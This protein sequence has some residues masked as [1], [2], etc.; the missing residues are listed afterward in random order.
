MGE[1]EQHR[2]IGWTVCLVF[3]VLFSQSTFAN[4]RRD[5]A[6]LESLVP[7]VVQNVQG[8]RVKIEGEGEVEE[9]IPKLS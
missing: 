7:E 2:N 6:Y 8:R 5:A 1:A 3:N 4:C 9:E